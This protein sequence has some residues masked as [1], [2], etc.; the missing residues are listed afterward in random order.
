MSDIVTEIEKL[1]VLRG[2]EF[3]R[4]VNSIASR[5]E[6]HLI[7]GEESIYAV[8]DYKSDDYVN[9]IVTARKAVEHGYRVYILPNPHGLRSADYIFEYK[10][11][12]ILYELK[13]IQGRGSAGT[14]LLQS[15]G[16]SNRVIL[17][18]A[19]DYNARLLASDIKKY[20]EA[21]SEAIE[22]LVFKG[23]KKISVTRR[24][25]INPKFNRLFRKQYEQ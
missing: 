16:Q 14:R 20:F 15:I 19:S 13:T 4:Q 8:G 11:I 1:H 7:E 18:I 23:N 12:R 25:C 2:A 9:L 21:N 5:P 17:N 24:F 3:S 22:V 10:Q 6:F